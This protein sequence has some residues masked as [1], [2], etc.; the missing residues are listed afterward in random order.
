[1][2]CPNCG[3]T[4]LWIW[5]Y[6][7]FAAGAYRARCKTCAT[8]SVK[9]VP[10]LASSLMSILGLALAAPMWLFGLLTEPQPWTFLLGSVFA[11]LTFMLCERIPLIFTTP[12]ALLT[13]QSAD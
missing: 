13:D 12:V 5:T 2:R 4:G 1:M 6:R 9:H 10:N 3:T 11:L 7:E 8:V